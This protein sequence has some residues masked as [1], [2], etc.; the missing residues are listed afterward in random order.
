MREISVA[1]VDAY[2]L[3]DRLLGIRIPSGSPLAGQSLGDSRMGLT[4]GLV[5]LAIQRSD[6]LL[7]LPSVETELQAGDRV[8]VQGNPNDLE[9]IRG[10]Q[11]MNI[12]RQ[13]DVNIANLTAG[14]MTLVE[15]ALSPYAIEVDQSLRDMRFRERYGLNVLAI[16]HRGR[17]YFS[18]LGG[19]HLEL[20]DAMLL[21]GPRI[22]VERLRSDENFLVLEADG[23]TDPRR[24]KA[25][26][27][28]ILMVA[29]VL[30]AILGWLPLAIAAI[31]GATLMVLTG[32]LTMDDAYRY[33]EWKA[34]FLIAGMLPLGIA[35]ETTGAAAFLAQTMLDAIGGYG[36]VAVLAGLFILTAL[37]AQ[38]MPNPVVA[39][40]I[41]PIALNAANAF[42]ITPY[43]FVMAVALA[44]SASFL[45]PIAHPANVLVMGPGGYRFADYIR[46]GLPVLLLLLVLSVILLPI[47]W[48]F[49][50]VG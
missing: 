26:I 1:S 14:P 12:D 22:N 8:I 40:L 13:P 48:P 20:G 9:V 19:W 43:A 4:F 2:Q 11:E 46:A 36:P 25:P 44:A 38:F 18:N 37:L 5:A 42:G 45:T 16:W 33:I 30:V 49:T 34:V 50:P 31:I 39:V 23:Q 3:Q 21:Y 27:A 28:V 10:L 6:D 24:N 7:L 15:V 47:F 17:A 35:L 32:C 41:A 29:V